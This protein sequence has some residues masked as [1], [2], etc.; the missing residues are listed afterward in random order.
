LSTVIARRRLPPAAGERRW[1][2]HL[3]GANS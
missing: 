3:S 1:T 2:A